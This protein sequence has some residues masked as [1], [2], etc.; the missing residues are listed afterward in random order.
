[1]DEGD[2]IKNDIAK[3]RRA[4]DFSLRATKETARAIGRSMAAFVATERHLW[5]TLYQISDKD[6]VFLLDAPIPLLAC[7]VMRLT[8]SS[9]GFRSLR[10]RRRLFSDFSLAVLKVRLIGRISPSRV[11]AP[12]IKKSKNRELPLVPLLKVEDRR[13]GGGTPGRSPQRRWQIWGPSFLI[14]RLRP[15]GPDAYGPGSLRAGPSGVKRYT[16]PYTVPVSPQCPQEIVPLPLP[17]PVLQG[18]AIS[19][20]CF[21]QLP[22]ENVAVLR[23]SLPPKKCLE[24]PFPAGLPL[25]GTELGVSM[26]P[27]HCRERV[28]DSVWITSTSI[29]RGV[30]HSGGPRAGSGN[31]TRSSYSLEEGGHRG[32]PSSRQRVRVLQP[33]L[34]RS[35]EGWG[36]A[37]YSRSEII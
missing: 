17:P 23:G 13:G 3:L 8:Q 6:R 21:S 28:Q 33:I 12:H 31:G 35:E 14:R 20:E 25:Q 4:T 26:G 2:D 18:T 19:S 16:P 1:M 10:N 29:Q 32:G 37:S 22:P 24:K 15:K 27:V 11:P 7:S 5:L 9:T 34:H 30:S 36:V